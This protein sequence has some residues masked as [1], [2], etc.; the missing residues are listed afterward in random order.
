MNG[1]RLIGRYTEDRDTYVVFAGLRI[2][3]AQAI[4]RRRTIDLES[5]PAD[6]LE[7][8]IMG[9]TYHANR[10]GSPGRRER[11]IVS[12]GQVIDDVRKVGTDRADRIAE[13][14]DR[15]HLNGMR[16]GCRHQIADGWGK[17]PIDPDKPTNTYGRHFT[18]Q[19]SP[20][21]NLLGWV[22]P[23]EHPEGLMGRA[24]PTCGYEYGTA[25]LYEPVPAEVIAELRTLFA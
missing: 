6:A 3:P 22:R 13:L 2:E 9:T 15:W 20:T 8:A 16:A 21:W 5:V 7:V 25:W 23:D 10:D 4:G 11:D 24:C 19:S 17:R 1:E 18:G 12:A 14:W